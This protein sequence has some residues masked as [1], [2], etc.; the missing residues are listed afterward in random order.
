M[1]EQTDVV[2]A[3]GRFP[4]PDPTDCL[5]EA[6]GVVRS[7]G[8]TPA[9][10]AAS[11]SVNAGEILAVMGPCNSVG[12]LPMVPWIQAFGWAFKPTDV[13]DVRRLP[14]EEARGIDEEIA[15]LK[16]E[17][18]PVSNGMTKVAPVPAG[19]KDEA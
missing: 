15:R 18:A 10:R 2:S 16:G 7:F 19:T 9:L 3:A 14:K 12:F 6:R 1:T 11:V 17:P 13:I 4:A 8:Q 5:I